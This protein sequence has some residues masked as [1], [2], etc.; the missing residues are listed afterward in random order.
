MGL[1]LEGACKMNPRCSWFIFKD[2]FKLSSKCLHFFFLS[3]SPSLSSFLSTTSAWTN[4]TLLTLDPQTLPRRA[5]KSAMAL[6]VTKSGEWPGDNLWRVAYSWA[7][8]FQ[9]LPL[10]KYDIHNHLIVVGGVR[11]LSFCY[12]H[13]YVVC[14]YGKLIDVRKSIWINIEM[15]LTTW[16]LFDFKLRYALREKSKV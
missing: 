5:L 10:G 8:D 1:H 13:S 6:Q 4:P 9:I 12:I 3:H 14:N 7:D 2:F 11:L 16:D 15:W